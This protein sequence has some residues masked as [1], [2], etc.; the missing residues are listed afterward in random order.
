MIATTLPVVFSLAPSLGLNPVWLGLLCVT[1]TVLG[2]LLP[3][4]SI[5]HL[6]TFASGYY[7]SGDMFKAG[8]WAMFLVIPVSLL[9]AH[10]YWPLLGISPYLA[11]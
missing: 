5:T 7:S 2:L 9:L 4:Q 10:L 1:S 3:T 6:V 11:Q 8:I